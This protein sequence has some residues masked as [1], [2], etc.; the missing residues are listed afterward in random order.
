MGQKLQDTS[1][2][3]RQPIPSVVDYAGH[4]TIFR[5][6]RVRAEHIVSEDSDAN[7]PAHMAMQKFSVK[8]LQV[9][10]IS[11]VQA[12]HKGKK[13][14]TCF[15]VVLLNYM[16]VGLTFGFSKDW[17]ENLSLNRM[18]KYWCNDGFM[19]DGFPCCQVCS[20]QQHSQ[21]VWRDWMQD[22]FAGRRD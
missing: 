17:L 14:E 2:Q 10:F 4:A 7:T 22:I 19:I 18:L 15:I 8:L 11:S 21:V 3:C 16:W 12:N 5:G 1:K 20:V 9:T 6:S 13:I